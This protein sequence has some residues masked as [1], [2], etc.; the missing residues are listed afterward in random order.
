MATYEDVMKY[1]EECGQKG[2]SSKQTSEKLVL[3]FPEV[4]FYAPEYDIDSPIYDAY[5]SGY[6]DWLDIE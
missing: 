1:A 5:I 4:D 3:Q 6:A 2:M